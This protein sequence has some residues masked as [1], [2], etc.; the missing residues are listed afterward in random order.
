MVSRES[1]RPST[2]FVQNLVAKFYRMA[3]AATAIAALVG[4]QVLGHCMTLMLVS[5]LITR[6]PG[7]E[8]GFDFSGLLAQQQKIVGGAKAWVL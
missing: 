7:A 2:T 5:L 6:P 8:T 1:H 3:P 4:A